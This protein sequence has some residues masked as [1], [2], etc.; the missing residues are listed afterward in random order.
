MLGKRKLKTGRTQQMTTIFG[1]PTL[2]G[3]E[4]LNP[5]WSLGAM[6]SDQNNTLYNKTLEDLKPLI[7]ELEQQ[8]IIG[9]IWS[10]AELGCT[11]WSIKA[12]EISNGPFGG[13][14]ATPILFVDNT[15]DSIAPIE[16]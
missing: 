3:Y 2:A 1:V 6:C 5:Q 4:A 11:G 7:K 15:Y 16:K 12:S 14:T 9:E 8:R 13:D 10:H